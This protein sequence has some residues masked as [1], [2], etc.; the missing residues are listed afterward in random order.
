MSDEWKPGTH[1]EY[2]LDMLAEGIFSAAGSS[3]TFDE[4][5][6]DAE[7]ELDEYTDEIAEMYY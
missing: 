2:L 7:K 3:K 4:C 6:A 5:R 1:R